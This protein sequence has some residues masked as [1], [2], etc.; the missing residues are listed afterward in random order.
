MVLCDAVMLISVL[1]FFP[2]ANQHFHLMTTQYCFVCLNAM[3][4]HEERAW[5][6]CNHHFHYGRNTD[7]LGSLRLPNLVDWK[8]PRCPLC[9]RRVTHS[10]TFSPESPI[11][12]DNLSPQY[13]YWGPNNIP[14]LTRVWKA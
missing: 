5:L 3:E 14:Q 7:S 10:L 1:A 4:I 9:L 11:P 2:V 12:K 6:R 8:D 13:W